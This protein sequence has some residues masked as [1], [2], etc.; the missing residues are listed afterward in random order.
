MET[1]QKILRNSDLDAM[2]LGSRSQRYEWIKQGKF[3]KP[4]PLGERSVGWLEP[5]VIEWQKA[6]LADR[7][8]GVKRKAPEPRTKKTAPRKT[9]RR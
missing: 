1:V 3:P 8:A 7:A 6:R 4:I 9:A 2:N 5:E